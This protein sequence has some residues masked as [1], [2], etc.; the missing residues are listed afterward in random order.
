MIRLRPTI[1]DVLVFLVFSFLCIPICSLIIFD[2]ISLPI[3]ISYY[4][5]KLRL[6]EALQIKK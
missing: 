3:K 1:F 6:G 5:Y 2:I 4:M